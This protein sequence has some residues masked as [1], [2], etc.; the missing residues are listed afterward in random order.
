MMA[1]WKSMGA[2]RR[3]WSLA[4]LVFLLDQL[5]KWI[6]IQSM[7][8]GAERVV[9]DGF[10]RF[11]HWGNT[12]AAW[13][14][15]RH[16]NDWLAGFSVAAVIVLWFS[17]KS[18]EFHRQGGQLALGLLFGGIFGNLIDRIRHDHVVDF[19][20]FYWIRRSGEEIG[21]PAF[22]VADMAISS[23]V[24]LL[25]FLTWQPDGGGAVEAGPKPE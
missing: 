19:L 11:V 2:N 16:R 10:F 5:T 8:L 7:V 3:T 6:V 1:L 9:L 15:F 13:S 24:G 14:V 23:S 21:F 25:L 20:R 18:F 22:N 12:G 4:A 17:R